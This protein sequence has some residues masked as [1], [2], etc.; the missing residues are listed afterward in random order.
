MQSMSCGDT[1]PTSAGIPRAPEIRTVR[2]A[3]LP[4]PNDEMTGRHT[5][6]VVTSREPGGRCS[7]ASCPSGR[8]RKQLAP[9]PLRRANEMCPLLRNSDAAAL[10]EGNATATPLCRPGTTASKSFRASA[11]MPSH[12]ENVLRVYMNAGLTLLP[13]LSGPLMPAAAP[14]A[15]SFDDA[16]RRLSSAS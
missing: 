10:M 15:T 8:S 2:L 11:A 3:C 13:A 7:A 5:V 14:P 9:L 12:D 4:R 1:R 6:P 16:A